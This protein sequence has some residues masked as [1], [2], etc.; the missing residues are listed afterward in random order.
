MSEFVKAVKLGLKVGL[1]IAHF[2]EIKGIDQ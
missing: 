1:K 2:L